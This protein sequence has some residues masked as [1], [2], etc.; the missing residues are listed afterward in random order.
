MGGINIWRLLIIAVIAILL[1]GTRKLGSLGSDL[2]TAIKGFKKAMSDGKESVPA[3]V[4]ES[5]EM[6]K[7][8]A[9]SGATAA[10]KTALPGREA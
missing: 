8:K 3:A 10:E 5:A 9:S 2:G 4:D 7:D 6:L 1:F